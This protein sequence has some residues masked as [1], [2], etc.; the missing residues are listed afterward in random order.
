MNAPRSLSGR[1]AVECY[2]MGKTERG[3]HLV[4]ISDIVCDLLSVAHRDFLGVIA[5]FDAEELDIILRETQK[6]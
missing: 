4:G 1:D 3:V 5:Q 6:L 2:R